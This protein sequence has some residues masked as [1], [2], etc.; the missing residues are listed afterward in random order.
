MSVFV[1]HPAITKYGLT[2]MLA[3][4]TSHHLGG[5]PRD[6]AMTW[7]TWQGQ[8]DYWAPAFAVLRIWDP[9]ASG[10]TLRAAREILKLR[11]MLEFKDDEP[12]LSPDSRYGSLEMEASLRRQFRDVTQILMETNT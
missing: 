5:L 12:D 1:R 11:R 4:E 8:A 9:R 10:A 6:P 7:M 2:L 3:H